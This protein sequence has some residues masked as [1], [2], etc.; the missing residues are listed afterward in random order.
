MVTNMPLDKVNEKIKE[1]TEPTKKPI[2]GSIPFE[3]ET[4][5]KHQTFILP[6]V[7]ATIA[8]DEKDEPV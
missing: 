3:E 2:A 5:E 7:S 8:I 4:E 1:I 6:F